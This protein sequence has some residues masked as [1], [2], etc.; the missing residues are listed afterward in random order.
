MTGDGEAARRVAEELS[1]AFISLARKGDP[2]HAGLPDWDQYRMP[3]RATMV[4]DEKSKLIDD[5]RK[6]ERELFSKVPF[7]QWGT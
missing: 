2:N 1:R 6:E 4:F 3:E 7:V 5:P